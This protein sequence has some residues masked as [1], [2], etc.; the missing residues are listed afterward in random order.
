LATAAQTSYDAAFAAYQ[1][2]VG[3]VTDATTAETQLLQ[4]QNAATDSYSAV[5]SAA[6]T[7]A[8][9]TGGLGAAPP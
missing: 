1:K 2:G 6:A 4:A 5:L 7:L 8:F 3:S 9:T